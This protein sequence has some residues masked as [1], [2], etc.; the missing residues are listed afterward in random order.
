MVTAIVIPIICLYFYWLTKKERREQ[1]RKWLASGDAKREAILIG[2]I[3]SISEEKQRFYYHRYIFVQELKLQTETK[4]V[5]M[6]KITPITTEAVFASFSIGEVVKVYGQWEGNEFHF[7]HFESL[8][9]TRN[10]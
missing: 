6:K 4:L 1:D 5:K 7:Q 10:K 3:K 2:E 9:A 8:S